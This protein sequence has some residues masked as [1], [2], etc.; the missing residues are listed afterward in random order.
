MR[1][2]IT[3]TKFGVVLEQE[4]HEHHHATFHHHNRGLTEIL[5]IINTGSIP[6]NVKTKSSEIFRKLGTVE[7]GIHGVPWKKSISTNSAPLIQSLIL[8]GQF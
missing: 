2:G 7:A 5:N 4:E 6:D 8:W 1:S 3:A